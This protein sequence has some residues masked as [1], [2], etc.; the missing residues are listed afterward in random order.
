VKTSEDNVERWTI[1]QRSTRRENQWR[2][3]IASECNL[4]SAEDNRGIGR[5]RRKRARVLGFRRIQVETGPA[6]VRGLSPRR[7]G[8]RGNN[9]NHSVVALMFYEDT[10]AFLW[11]VESQFVRETELFF[12]C[13][14]SRFLCLRLLPLPR[15]FTAS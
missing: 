1:K 8:G 14:L 3:D 7:P 15:L 12:H 10:Y 9:F 2:N 6:E 11:S 5:E 13:P 4:L